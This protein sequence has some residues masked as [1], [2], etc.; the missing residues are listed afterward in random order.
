[1]RKELKVLLFKGE[2]FQKSLFSRG[3]LKVDG[4]NIRKH[5]TKM[6][7]R[8]QLVLFALAFVLP[9]FNSFRALSKCFK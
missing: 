8:L 6:L 5:P 9:Q 7:T 2:R 1:M 4:F 3:F